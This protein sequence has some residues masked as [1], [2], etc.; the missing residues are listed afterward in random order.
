MNPAAERLLGWNLAEA[1]GHAV[2]EVVPLRDAVAGT[3][4]ASPIRRALEEGVTLSSKKGALLAGR[5][6]QIIP[7]EDSA[8]P[9]RDEDD[10]PLGAVLIVRDVSERM[11]AQALLR[12][13]EER[14]RN[15]FDF[16]PVGMA[17][18]GLDN[19]FLQVN[20]AL[21]KL[22]GCSEAELV[23]ADQSAFSPVPDEAG[24]QARLR[25]LVAG[26]VASVQFEKTFRARAGKDLWTI[27][28][29][30]LL[31]RNGEPLCYLCQVHDLTERKN[32]EHRLE[33]LAHFDALTGLA[34]RLWLGQEIERQIVLARRH[35][36]RLA[37]VFLD[38]DHFKQVNDS[39]GHEA[40]DELIRMVA[41]KLKSSL[42]GTD[43][44]ARLGGDEFVMLLPDIRR[45]EEV[46][47]VTD[48]VQAECARPFR[49]AGHEMSIGISLGV[50]LFPDDA[51]DARTLLRY[52]DSALYYAKAEGRNNLKFY[53]P[54]LTGRL[55]QRMKLGVGLRLAIERRE[56]ML[57]FQPL[58]RLADGKTMGCEAL[59]RWNHP[60]LG[61]LL[62]D[63]FSPLAEET[64]LSV[65]IG[66]WVIREA[67]REAAAWSGEG[68]SA[69]VLSVNVSPR[70]FRAG[71]LVQLIKRALAS[72]GLSPARLCVEITEQLLLENS[73]QNLAT[74]AALKK[75]GVRIAIDDFGT[76][77]SSLSYIRRFSPSELKIDTS[78]V[79]NVA[80]DPDDA[81]IVRAAIA[82]A[83]S[84][85]ITVVTEGVETAAQE[86]FLKS[87]GCDM[88]Q[89]F[90]YG[91]PQPGPPFR[92]W[93]KRGQAAAAGT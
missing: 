10:R 3:A 5:N 15:A 78:L 13:S 75:L 68:G 25:E 16:A 33:H 41:A 12:Q 18:V 6:G 24:E 64:G 47:I 85:K 2:E 37:V 34:N 31:R 84:L 59:I 7:I 90:L 57:V 40:G 14:F 61:T 89:G 38:I 67:C 79:R 39:L 88:A 86:A 23:G 52:A 8:A 76:G 22:L 82:M 28:S 77:Y 56:F 63:A 80:S 65:P 30:S 51:E 44:V 17:L 92:E 60:E 36:R 46:L 55:E 35:Q 9:I 87:E 66:A 54:E 81:A 72:S 48:K 70:Q 11:A 91:K 1:A 49:V 58:V 19:R 42:R 83:H 32:A 69:P 71:N 4:V 50:S 29:V 21:C 27:V 43:A 53:R 73:E 26:D 93:L 45:A 74:L 62:P 20:A